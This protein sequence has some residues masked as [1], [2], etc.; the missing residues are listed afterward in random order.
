MNTSR[1]GSARSLRKNGGCLPAARAA[2]ARAVF[3]SGRRSRRRARPCRPCALCGR[4]GAEGDE[5]F[6]I[7]G[8][9][10]ED[11]EP[12]D[13]RQPAEFDLAQARDW[14][15]PAE[16]PAM[17]VEPDASPGSEFDSGA[18]DARSTAPGSPTAGG[19]TTAPGTLAGGCIDCAPLAPDVQFSPQ[20]PC[21]VLGASVGLAPQ[22][23]GTAHMRDRQSPAIG[24]RLIV[25]VAVFNP[26]QFAPKHPIGV[27][28][29]ERIVN[30]AR[31]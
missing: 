4:S 16:D 2:G 31:G 13:V 14:L 11:E 21:H 17:C 24:L 10:R 26:R 5:P 9:A 30:A 1:T 18:Q 22:K 7:K 29:F 3:P 12:L 23:L 20:S 25:T 27:G 6:H 19:R 8:G 15:D 28:R